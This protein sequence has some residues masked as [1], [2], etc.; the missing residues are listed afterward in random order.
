MSRR[1]ALTLA[2]LATAVTVNGGFALL[3]ASAAAA[4]ITYT[5]PTGD[6]KAVV[7]SQTADEDADLDITGLS[8][9]NT[10]TELIGTI[11]VKKLAANPAKAPGHGFSFSYTFNGKKFEHSYYKYGQSALDTAAS[12]GGITY[13]STVAGTSRPIPVAATF[14]LAK[15]TATLKVQLADLEPWAFAPAFNAELTALGARTGSD[16]F[17]EGVPYDSLAAADSSYRIRYGCGPD[18]VD[19]GNRPPLPLRVTEDEYPRD[20]CFL[21]TD[22]KSDGTPIIAG[23]ATAPNEPDVDIVGLNVNTTASEIKAFIKVD[24]LADKPANFT[25]DRFEV[26]FGYLGKTFTFAVGRFGATPNPALPVVGAPFADPNRGQVNGTTNAALKPTGTFD[27]ATNTV[28]IGISRAALNTAAGEDV[29]LGA[30]LTGVLAKTWAY[31]PGLQ[32]TADTATNAA[33]TKYVVGF[34]RCFLPPEAKLTAIGTPS[35]Q[36]GD[37]VALSAK[38]ENENGTA[39][40]GKTVKFTLGATT[41]NATTNGAGVAVANVVDTLTA[42][43]ATYSVSFAGDKSAG[44]A[45]IAAPITVR[46][47]VTKLTLAVAKSGSTRTVTATLKDDDGKPLAGQTLLWTI[48]GKAAGSAKTDA[49]GRA[50]LKT[51]KPTQ[52]VLVKFA[53]VTGKYATSQVSVKV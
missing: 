33:D 38:L 19:G 43:D 28:V 16:Y 26:I 7:A 18:A 34:S 1:R 14:D 51:A 35:V 5:D 4:C 20:D 32:F 11:T 6:A 52:T 49:A 41:V 48:N 27:K 25:G 30:V 10:A 12:T 37:E 39:L 9:N 17:A 50:V 3:S 44:P 31:Q 29:P 15:N 21:V 40:S 13:T 45:A 36:F 2:A 42:G 53:G 23:P 47:E 8:L 46:L 22:K 24:K